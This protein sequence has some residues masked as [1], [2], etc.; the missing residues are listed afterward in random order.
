MQRASDLRLALR[1]IDGAL[2]DTPEVE[3]RARGDVS[4]LQESAGE[5]KALREAP[6]LDDFTADYESGIG[7]DPLII[8]ELPPEVERDGA[9][10]LISTEEADEIRARISVHGTDALGWYVTF[11]QTA[12]QWGAYI[13]E[14]D[15]SLF[16]QYQ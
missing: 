5:A 2:R 13:S 1:E 7:A 15:R 4:V 16:G 10:P 9:T 8:A 11:H 6:G 3:H 14:S 12:H